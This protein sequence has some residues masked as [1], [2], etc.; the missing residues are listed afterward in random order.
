M[1][2]QSTVATRP[3]RRDSEAHRR[4]TADQRIVDAHASGAGGRPV[5]LKPY[6]PETLASAIEQALGTGNQ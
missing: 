5:I 1:P 2:A 3:G 6:K 4:H